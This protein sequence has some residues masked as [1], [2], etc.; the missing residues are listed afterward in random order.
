[1]FMHWLSSSHWI[2]MMFSSIIAIYFIVAGIM[3]VTEIFR[4][5]FQADKSPKSILRRRYAAGEIDNEEHEQC[6]AKLHDTRNA[7]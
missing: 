7:A 3:F 4:N 6:L 2:W 1:M 5:R